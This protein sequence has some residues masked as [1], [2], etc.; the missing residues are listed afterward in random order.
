MTRFALA[1]KR[2][3]S[4]EAI[5]LELLSK[6]VGKPVGMEVWQPLEGRPAK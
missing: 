3:A 6:A 1:R 4:E 5:L 2:E